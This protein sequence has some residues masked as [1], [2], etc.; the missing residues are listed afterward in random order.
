[1]DAGTVRNVSR[2]L[3]TRKTQGSCSGACPLVDEEEVPFTV[4]MDPVSTGPRP[5]LLIAVVSPEPLQLSVDLAEGADRLF[6]RLM[7]EAA[8]RGHTLAAAAKYVNV[9]R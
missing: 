6:E 3:G 8:S 4:R 7:M 9:T 5:R 2:A 1:D